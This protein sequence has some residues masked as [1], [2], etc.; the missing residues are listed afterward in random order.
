ML[1]YSGIVLAGGYS[2]RMGEDKALLAVAGIPC[3]VRVVR[4]LATVADDVWVVRRAEQPVLATKALPVTGV[5]HDLRTGEGPLAGMEVGFSHMRHEWS[6]VVPAD[7]PLIKRSLLVLMASLCEQAR[8]AH[9]EIRALIMQQRDQVYP[10][11]GLYHHS[12]RQ[13]VAELLDQGS[14]RVMDLLANLQVRYITEGE[15][16]LADPEGVSF[17]MMNTQAQ[18]EAVCTRLDGDGEQ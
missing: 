1:N 13:E 7:A 8:Q 18:Y 9:T 5:V 3:Y 15:W 6:F 17:M 10:L 11:M 16:Q 4:T 2:R 12:V 14:R